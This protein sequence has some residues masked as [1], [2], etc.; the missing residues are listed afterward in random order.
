MEKKM[1]TT[2]EHIS[3]Y[4]ADRLT[5]ENAALLL[6]DHQ[7]GLALGVET[8][9]PETFRNNVVAIAKVGKLFDLPTIVTTSAD[10]GPNGPLMPDI[11]KVFPDLE[12]IRRKGEINAWDDPQFK[13]AVE[14]TGRKKLIIAGIST[15]V[16]LLFPVLSAISEGYDVYAV[17]DS[18]GTWN[19]I[20]QQTTMMRLSQAGC[21][22]TNW[23][24][25]AAELQNDW[26]NPTGQ[27]LA[28]L[29]NDHLTFYGHLISNLAASAME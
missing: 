13:A 10:S 11:T 9:N 17:F 19:E 27:G 6:I 22:T 7:T 28:G 12:V 21:K 1:A 23:V 25:V 18:S 20:A 8:M 24:S 2:S 29:F 4:F 5:P 3:T 15:D 16:C 26:R 14:A